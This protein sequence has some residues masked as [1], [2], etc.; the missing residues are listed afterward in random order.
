MKKFCDFTKDE[1]IRFRDEA[2]KRYDDILSRSLKIDMSRGKPCSEQL[3]IV[4]GDF[5]KAFA[6]TDYRSK[7]GFDCRNYGMLTGIDEA[8]E[9]FA[10]LL[11]VDK[12]NIIVGGNASLELMFSFM[13]QCYSNGIGGCEPWCRQGNVK[14]IA[15]VPGYDRHFGIAEYF[16]IEMINVPINADGPDMDMVEEIIKDPSVKGMFCVPKYSNP[17]GYTYSDET[18]DRLGKMKPAAKDFRVIWDNAYII[19]DLYDEG[20]ELYNI[21]EAAE[22]YGNADNF[23]EF[24]STSKISFPG[25]GVSALAASDN[26]IK[27]I[28]AR[29]SKQVISYDKMNQLRHAVVFPDV[30]ALNAE[31]K[32]HAQILRPKFEAVLDILDRELGGLDVASWHKPM[33]GYF[34][35]LNVDVGS[36]KYAG[37]LCKA[38]GLT[39][40]GVGATYPCGND[41]DD[42]N[43]RIAPSYPPV[44]ELKTSAELLCIAVKLAAAKTVL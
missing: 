11:D 26:N 6:M 19:H 42:R 37:E 23:I 25:S 39:L 4:Q 1:V 20:D 36:A 12:K 28:A 15:V 2:Q 41:P 9:L 13:S 24:C 38:A 21:F 16:G 44:D 29:M 7:S 43:I 35:S 30:E 3:D 33:G 22:K 17:D 32:K 40:T 14:F 34:I 18:V 31:M 5:E 27:E 10:S 8:K